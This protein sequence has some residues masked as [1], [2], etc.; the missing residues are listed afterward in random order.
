MSGVVSGVS[1]GTRLRTAGTTYLSRV[2]TT[3]SR[4]SNSILGSQMPQ[5]VASKFFV[6]STNTIR[7]RTG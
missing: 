4:L 5:T 7:W 1:N 3:A 2:C 6:G